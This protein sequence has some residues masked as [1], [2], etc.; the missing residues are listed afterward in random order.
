MRPIQRPKYSL[1]YFFL[2]AIGLI[3]IAYI[4]TAILGET[5]RENK[6]N[7]LGDL[8]LRMCVNT[9]LGVLHYYTVQSGR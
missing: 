2:M 7:S 9:Q 4:E 5:L 1:I 3:N 6:D 8:S